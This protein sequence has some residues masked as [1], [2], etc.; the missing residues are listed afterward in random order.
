MIKAMESNHVAQ[1]NAMQNILIAMERNSANRFQPRKNNEKSQKRGP[2]QDQRP[3]NPLE[4]TNMVNE[5]APPFC[6]ACEDFHEESTCPVFCQVNELGFPETS[7][8][9]GYSRRFDFINNVGKTHTITKDQLK[10]TKELSKQSKDLKVDNVTRLYGEKPTPEQILEMARFKGVTYQ[11]RRN[12]NKSY[13]NIPKT[14]TPP[15]ADLSV[16]LGSWIANA[17]VLVPVSELIKIPSQKEKLLK[18][19][20]G[21]NERSLVKYQGKTVEKPKDY[22]E[23]VLVVLHSMDWTKEDHPPFFVSLWIND[24]VLHNYM[25][26][27]RASS[28][29]MTKNV[30]ERLNLKTTRPYHNVCAMDS[31]EIEIHGIIVNLQVKLAAHPDITFPM[32]ILVIDVPDA[33]GMLLSRKWVATMGGCIQIDLSYATIPSPQNSSVRLL[34]EKEKKVPC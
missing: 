12:D 15:T 6:R 34:R 20:E 8:F 32:D 1:L 24:L 31:R 26:D 17:K 14:L 25:Y 4:S 21:P 30:M 2:P 33:W 18:A 9:V 10:Q 13:Q 5:E 28:N 27:S 11:K 7:N 16:D 23:D 3:P 19:I 22:P 29:I